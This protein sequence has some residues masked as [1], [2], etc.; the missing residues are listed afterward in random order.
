VPVR[1]VTWAYRDK[2]SG[3]PAL[4]LHSFLLNSTLWTDQLNS[5]G[6]I[7]RCLAPDMR[8]W[9]ASE[10]VSDQRLDPNDYANDV[11]EFLD[12]LGVKEP[13]DLVG[14]SV[15]AFIAGLVYE[16]IPNRVASITLV[17]GTFDFKR[18]VVYER[19]QQE[20]ARLVTVEGKDALFRRFDE[21]ID[22]PMASLHRRARYHQMLL[23]TRTEMIVAFLTSTGRNAPRPDLPGK[24]RV[25][26]LL[27]V[28]TDD[29]VITPERADQMARTF[30]SAR[31]IRLKG[32]GRLL[33]LESPDEFNAALR[34]LWTGPAA[35]R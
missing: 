16:K 12:T 21:Y 14:L 30:P 24:I 8:G 28:G 29:V 34:E 23:D 4:F 9:G 11:V 22:S 35:R 15:G 31:V 10:P 2:G 27:P 26:V 6:D 5:L 3:P 20:M 17:S 1:G 32:A 7:R 13:V 33:P 25:P 18:D 19:Y